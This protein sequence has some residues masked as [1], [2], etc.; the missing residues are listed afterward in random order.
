M[1]N[2]SG[3]TVSAKETWLAE[4][5]RSCADGGLGS[6]GPDLAQVAESMAM[7][8]G[9]SSSLVLGWL[10]ACGSLAEYASAALEFEHDAIDEEQAGNEAARRATLPV[11]Q[12][13]LQARVDA[14]DAAV[15]GAVKCSVCLENSQSRGMV[16][17]PW[18][19]TLGV[20][21]LTRRWSWCET[22]KCG[23][24]SAQRWLRLPAGPHTAHLDEAI[25]RVAT[26]VTHGMAVELVGKLL[27]VQVSEHGVQNVVEDRGAA[28]VALQDA[29]AKSLN[30][31]HSDGSERKRPRPRDA[32]REVPEVAYIEL[33]GVFAMTRQE[34]PDARVPAEPGA[35]GGKGR[36]YALEGKE[37]KNAV[38]YTAQDCV[39]ESDRRGALLHKQYVSHQGTCH[40]FKRL[41][42]VHLRRLRFDQ[43]KLCVVL[44]DGADWIRQ[45][46]NWLP[47]SVLLILDLFHAKHRIWEVAN[48][49]HG[50][51]TAEAGAWAGEQCL[52]VEA[53]EV[54][55]V[56]ESLRFLKSRNKQA[57]E[58]IEA[59][60]TYFENNKDRMDYP[61]YRA[62]GLRVSSA[63]VESANYHV[64][65]A[66]M[67]LQGM[68]WSEEGAA[69]M[70][71]LRADLFN[72]NW[73]RRTRELMA[74]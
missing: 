62:R 50:E 43:A 48:A 46:A 4:L 63:A 33:D 73:E 12:A 55:G 38:L 40:D 74:A 35:R 51:R 6:S 68:R 36:R 53:G 16:E 30:P 19:S 39:E 66:R 9:A 7:R 58:M 47:F 25:S 17:R 69:Q 54:A 64:T 13:R 57:G 44:S 23:V 71:R 65:G 29:E 2:D 67:K 5:A 45:L 26:T 61:A 27:G 24:S 32:V 28:L 15:V 1:A 42:W 8:L 70:A 22:D 59:L 52:R 56:I 21:R 37:I 10:Q 20:I 41:L 31:E 18:Q 34:L 49:L 72:G 60:R 11:L 3:K 14:H